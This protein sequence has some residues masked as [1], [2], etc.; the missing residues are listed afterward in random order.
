MSD[1]HAAISTL[2]PEK[3]ILLE[4]RLRKKNSE[5]RLEP[6]P[7]RQ[8]ASPSQLSFAQELMWLLD[9]L[10]DCGA[11]H[12]PRA[13]RIQGP[14][15]VEALQ[16]ALNRVVER[17]EILRTNY[18][19]VDDTPLQVVSQSAS[20]EIRHFDLST[21]PAADREQRA[22]RLLFEE[23]RK[24]FD[25][26]RDL[27]LRSLLLKMDADNHIL[28]LMTHHIASDGES[29]EVLF[30]DL[31][32]YYDAFLKHTRPQ[33]PELGIQ[34]ADFAVWQRQCLTGET[35]DRLLTYWRKQLDGA[36]KLMKFPTD[37]HRPPLQSF[38]GSA[39]TLTF[40]ACL[41]SAFKDLSH[42]ER[43][44]LF[45]T[46]LAAFATLL[47]R[48]SGQTDVVIGT[49]VS[50]R[51]RTEFEPLIGYFSNTLALRVDLSGNPTFREL[52]ARVRE[53]SL[54]AYSHQE[55]PFER[56][57]E[58]QPERDVSY[59]PIF[60]AMF[61]VGEQWRKPLTLP[62][63]QVT[64]VPVDL[65]TA[66]LD[67]N[68]GL[69]MNEEQKWSG[70]LTYCTALFEGS[71]IDR[72]FG[73]F[74]NLLEA[75]VA[76]PEERIMSLRLLSERERHRVV[77]EWNDTKTPLPQARTIHR[78][79]EEQVERTPDA[80]AV[81]C[82]GE[83]L[84]YRHLNGRS[85][86]LAHFLRERGVG[87]EV[88]VGIYLR[89]SLNLPVALLGVLK[90]G[91]ACVPID[92]DYPQERIALML[93]EV[94]APILVTEADLK[95]NMQ[96]V[97]S[98]AIYL[99]RDWQDFEGGSDDNPVDGASADN[100]AY[101]I[102]TSG[103]T[104]R[105][106]GVELSHL[107]LVNHNAAAV[108]L[109]QLEPSDRVLQ[110]SSLSFDI[111]VEE[112]FPTWMAGGTLVIRP[113]DL[114]LVP[115]DF[116]DWIRENRITVLDL[117]TAYWHE[118][119][120]ELPELKTP[121]PETLRL[122]ILGG[123][124]ASPSAF[125]IWRKLAGN[126]VRLINTYGPTETSVIATAY[127]PKIVPGEDVPPILPIGRPI[128][129]T[130]TYILDVG[131]NPVPIGVAG[132]LYI[133]GLGVARGYLN[134]GDLTAEKFILDP[135]GAESGSRLYRTGDL[136]RY[137]ADGNIEFLGRTDNQIKIRGY[138]VEPG[139]IESALVEHPAIQQAFVLLREDMPGE[140]HLVAYC[141]PAKLADLNGSELRGFL[142]GK[143]PE[144][145]IP[146]S[147]VMLDRLPL[148]PNGKVQVS[149]LPSPDKQSTATSNDF[150]AP[151]TASETA[152]AMIWSDLLQVSPI[153]IHDNFFELG[154]HS[155]LGIQVI[156]RLR[157]QFDLNL[158]L[159]TLFENPT[160]SE[161]SGL[162]DSSEANSKSVE[163]AIARRD[164]RVVRRPM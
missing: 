164:R 158:P 28:M 97:T 38:E 81:T 146:S 68:L 10:V 120:H 8:I 109:Y 9:Q 155:L 100:L 57:V 91:G 77:V 161:L 152:M 22:G 136:A 116:L 90:A 134:R 14:L 64:M 149:A 86:Q 54:G 20:V 111:A 62:G 61:S 36:P 7:R 96:E 58:L 160:I 21:L 94:D 12:V 83:S 129:N 44:T 85:N 150:V 26:T 121:L 45:M 92:P 82:H 126:S 18:R 133:G 145:M 51:S 70:M 11:Y 84:T 59:N 13:M 17:H 66:K 93:Q 138:R 140:K 34:Y 127:E 35:L 39:K 102:F 55:L 105:P 108:R 43:T 128:A 69:G 139:E 124:R 153:G 74:Q 4:Q 106:R 112:I 25:L 148:S 154:G 24:R 132:E 88:P 41:L 151:E 157:K 33:L 52:M 46:T 63:L 125:A 6:V 19:T 101:V 37:H 141:V 65:H 16:H 50:G 95:A 49:P 47:S 29:R 76:N 3:R 115:A 32:A 117:P 107:G 15:N 53:V 30:R 135:F 2:S 78:R 79:V 73:H 99:P 42:Q 67:M 118:W 98:E 144:Y 80:T 104:G 40:P 137:L 71:T 163:V 130:S 5:S 110:F 156:S 31:H 147:F 159:R 103:S 113:D 142:K 60:Q 75:V 131:Q 143:L 27:L 89:R 1:L 48:Y 114:S 56:L 23:G 123:E 119:V 87:P 162:V 122:V 72:V